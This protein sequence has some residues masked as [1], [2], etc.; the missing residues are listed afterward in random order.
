MRKTPEQIMKEFAN[1][2]SYNSW[3]E[4]M[5]DTHEHTQIEYTK[6]V[7]KIYAKQAF[8]AAREL[9]HGTHDD[10]NLYR[11]FDNFHKGVMDGF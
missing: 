8:N 1:E 11:N 10:W 2:H 6:E 9:C 5:Y 7:M 4:L 3:G